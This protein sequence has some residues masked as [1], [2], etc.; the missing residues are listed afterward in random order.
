MSEMDYKE[1]T[2]EEDILG[3]YGGEEFLVILQHTELKTA[4]KISE[5]IRKAVEELSWEHNEQVT[6]SGGLTYYTEGGVHD[7]VQDVDQLLYKAKEAGRNR[8][9]CSG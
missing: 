9:F 8:I 1:W 3:R 4:R 6:I 7:F 2:R 5:R